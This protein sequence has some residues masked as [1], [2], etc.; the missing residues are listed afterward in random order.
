MSR[1][2]L[3][4]DIS[5]IDIAAGF[6][7]VPMCVRVPHTIGRAHRVSSRPVR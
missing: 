5:G 3:D 1:S 7:L 4:N 6:E 2:H